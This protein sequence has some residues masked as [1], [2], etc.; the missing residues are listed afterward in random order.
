M[1]QIVLL[2]FETL[3]FIGV[4]IFNLNYSFFGID[5]SIFFFTNKVCAHTACRPFSHPN[6]FAS[7][8]WATNHNQVDIVIYKN[9]CMCNNLYGKIKVSADIWLSLQWLSQIFRCSQYLTII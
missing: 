4:Y 7:I 2:T 6:S 8:N 1:L 5:E 9:L 3:L